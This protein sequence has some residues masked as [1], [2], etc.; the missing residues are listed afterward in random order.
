MTLNKVTKI[1]H[2]LPAAIKELQG[3]NV[4]V[5]T[6]A[7]ANTNMALA[8]IATEDTI[9]SAVAYTGGVPANATFTVYAAG[10]VRCAADMTG[11]TIVVFWF[12]KK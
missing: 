8:G 6:G 3:L 5:V 12:N 1:D 10:Q 11:K 2:A 4:T 9:V 7:A